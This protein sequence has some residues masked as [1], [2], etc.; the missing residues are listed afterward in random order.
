M[1][2]AHMS[3]R[4]H[5]ST[6]ID[7]SSDILDSE[8]TDTSLTGTTGS[9]DPFQWRPDDSHPRRFIQRE[10]SV[11]LA[12]TGERV[13][14][15]ITFSSSATHLNESES[16]V[17]GDRPSPLYHPSSRFDCLILQ[18]LQMLYY[19]KTFREVMK[20]CI[21]YLIS[22]LGVYWAPFDHF[23]GNT[24]SKHI[25][26]TVAIYF[27]PTRTKGSMHQTLIFVII[28]VTFSFAVSLACRWISA[29]T[30]KKGA[31]EISHLI[32][33]VFSSVALGIVAFMKQKVNKETFNTAC[34]LAS[35]TIVLCIIKEGSLNSA[36][37][38]LERIESTFKVVLVGCLISVGCCYL[39]WPVSAVNQL[40]GVL[41]DS[42]NLFSSVL[43]ILTR[44][45]I[46]GEQFTTKDNEMIDKL[47]SNI[48]SLLK[49]LEEA[50]YELRLKGREDEWKIFNE[51]VNS[52][53]SLA[54]HLQALTAAV[55]MQWTLLN[56]F[57]SHEIE[58]L[59]NMSFQ[60]SAGAS[61]DIPESV[62]NMENP[63]APTAPENDALSSLQLF[64]LFVYYLTP[65][66]RSLVFTIKG[67][68]SQ[69]PFEK[70]SEEFP[71]QF[72]KT[73]TL[74]HSL[75]S[76]IKLYEEK[77]AQSLEKLYEQPIFKR[78]ADFLSTADQEEVGA[79]CGNFSTLLC[80]FALKLLEFIKL[81]EQYEEARAKP[82]QWPWL[83]FRWRGPKGTTTDEM[84]AQANS[85]HAALDDLKEQYGLSGLKKEYS[86][87]WEY[88]LWRMSKVLKRTDVQF[89]IR[90]GLGAAFLAVFAYL[91]DTKEIFIT[92]RGEWALTVYCI[93]MN[94]SVGGTSLT[95]KWRIIGTLLGCYTA[96]VIWMITDANVFAL[97]FTGFLISIPSFYII[98]YWKQNQSFGRFILLA[99][100]LTALYSY[101]MLQK[102]SEDDKE[103]GENPL[104]SE[105]AF[106]RFVAVSVGIVWALS[107]AM[108][109][110]PT[111]ARARLKRGLPIL[112]LR[113]GVIWNSDPLEYDP[114]TM[115]LVGF[116]AEEGTNKL[117]AE[118]ETLL[119]HAP[120]EVR[121]K[122]PFP[123]SAYTKLIRETS[124]IL[125]AFQNL[126]LLI[127]VDTTLSLNEEYVLKYIAAERDEVE[128]RIFL[129]FYML[130]STMRLGFPLPSKPASI[131]HA[132]DRLLYKLHEIRGLQGQNGISLKNADFVLLYSYILV[133]SAVSE[134]LENIQNQIKELLGEI[135][136]D[137][138]QLV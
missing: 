35:I 51:L 62:I 135:S 11:I 12:T 79:C 113:L 17:G 126:D 42:Y 124:S 71:N 138:F 26:A 25:I 13:H 3:T 47:K 95:V 116:K 91:G 80:N 14:R 58:R 52:T 78:D 67:V 75:D 77:Q 72:A 1:T 59:S 105:I 56:D 111:S 85:L 132:K 69:V 65:S 8:T 76:A 36:A 82:R 112:W 74:Q 10:S 107:M 57:H 110:L 115:H 88:G 103:G 5:P 18:P 137:K 19:D 46:A 64:D 121:L 134:R 89:G 100:N 117:L 130:A 133:A 99:Y 114:E 108:F 50:K 44:R 123:V 87:R 53:I 32:D 4:K 66:I 60:S 102:D 28:S 41:N 84:L 94:R 37:V 81:S 40:Q 27:H 22:T 129:V 86:G 63:N 9:Y 120:L 73:T 31:D 34:S 98:L 119:K 122:G 2:K 49:S 20:C 104:I 92:W 97:S 48:S 43:S 38:P 118:C 131:E 54:R 90:V 30:Y 16:L 96:Y 45:F 29:I 24:D 39:L 21:A 106:H 136:E 61:F 93:M 125:D 55:K 128:H 109:F 68:L 101:S 83:S 6:N 23:F 70:Y 127:K 15:Q 7:E 33:L